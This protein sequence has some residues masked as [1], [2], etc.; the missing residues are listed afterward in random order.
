MKWIKRIIG[1]VGALALV[2]MLAWGL[3]PQAALVT[4]AIV[5]PA[6]LRVTVTEEGRTRVRDRYVVSAPVPG[7][8]HRID[9]DVGDAVEAGQTLLRLEP[10]RSPGLDP[11]S[12]AEAE[13]R[14]AA[15]RAAVKAR[16]QSARAAAAEAQLA[17]SQRRRVLELAE[18]G[19]VSDEEVDQAQT[20][21]RRAEA[22]RRSSEFAADVARFELAE[23]EAVVHFSAVEEVGDEREAVDVKSPVAGRVLAVLHESEGVVSAG[24]SLVSVGDPAALEIEVE[25][26][27]ADAVRIA[28]GMTV[29]VERWGGE[30]PLQGRVQRVEPVAFTK[31]SALGVE[32]QR[33]LV[34]VELISPREQWKR[35]GDAYRVEATFLIWSG[36][37]VLQVP[38]GALFRADGGWRVFVVEDGRARLRAVRLGQR[39][40]LFSEVLDGIAE[41]E[42]VI[43]HP[44]DRL[45]DEVTV[46]VSELPD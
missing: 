9:L 33:A 19:E 8:A 3:L 42:R 22:M 7:Y 37:R 39:G 14:V 17:E 11:R 21:S 6:P 36:D 40:G 29:E 43:M 44:G 20:A 13:A 1:V 24:E 34:I 23:A 32:E 5:G 46:R 25:A 35:L 15:A 4:T 12:R 16:E 38:T 26:L 27:S 2:A 45:A 41:G 10:L 31:V 28:E 30:R 18:A